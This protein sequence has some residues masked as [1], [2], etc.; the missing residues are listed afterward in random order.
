MGP[1]S[2]DPPHIKADKHCVLHR[3]G[4]EASTLRGC[5]YRFAMFALTESSHVAHGTAIP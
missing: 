5:F 2:F 3:A 4:V 1:H